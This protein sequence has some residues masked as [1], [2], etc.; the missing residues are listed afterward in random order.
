MNQR[1]RDWLAAGLVFVIIGNSVVGW[2]R[3]NLDLTLVTTSSLGLLGL[4]AGVKPWKS[5][6]DGE[7]PPTK[8]PSTEDN[9]RKDENA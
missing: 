3:G 4:L 7:R 9:S 2:I 5:N 6:G 8:T 1:A